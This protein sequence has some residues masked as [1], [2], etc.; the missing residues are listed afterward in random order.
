MKI[1]GKSHCSP[2]SVHPGDDKLY[3]DMKQSFWW[4]NMKWEVAEFVAKCR[5]CQNVKIEHKMS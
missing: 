3:K 4:P 5:I 1:N 2:Y